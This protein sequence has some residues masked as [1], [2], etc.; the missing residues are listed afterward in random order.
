MRYVLKLIAVALCAAF[1]APA[2]ASAGL[3]WMDWDH[4]AASRP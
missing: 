2:P 3:P 4:S 1:L